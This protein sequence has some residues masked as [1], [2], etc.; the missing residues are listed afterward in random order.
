MTLELG[1]KYPHSASLFKFC[2]RVL[3]HKY[4]SARVIDQDIGQILDFDPADCSHW[5]KGKKNVHSISAVRKIA[6]HLGVDERLIFDIA[7]GDLNDV[8]AYFEFSG[9]EPFC[10]NQKYLETAK[11]EYFRK[12]THHWSIEKETEFKR[13][14]SVDELEIQNTVKEIHDL[15]K[16]VEPPLYLPEIVSRYPHIKLLPDKS[17]SLE[18]NALPFKKIR[19]DKDLILSFIPGTETKPFVRYLLAKAMASYFLPQKILPYQNQSMPEFQTHLEDV[20]INLFAL[21]LLAPPALVRK[22]MRKIDVVKDIVSQLA[23]IFWVSKTFMNKCLQT[24]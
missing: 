8:E 23:E 11:K 3:D 24:Y 18:E 2:R 21:Y 14:F 7:S 6:E 12:E 4:A 20:R 17:L 1:I 13:I 19:T 5:K 10:I 16:F 15:I 22:E 9:Y